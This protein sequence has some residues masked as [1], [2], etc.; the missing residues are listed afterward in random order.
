MTIA[1]VGEVLM[2]LFRSEGVEYIFGLPGLTEVRFLD[3]LEN[4][5]EIKYIMGLN[6]NVCIGMADGYT[7]AS[8]KIGV[9]NLHTIAGTSAALGLLLNSYT[10]EVPL[11][12][13][14]GQQDSRL[15]AQEPRLWGDLVKITESFTKWGAE[16]VYS[17]D[18]PRIIQRAFKTALQAPTGP[19]FVSLP[20]NLFEQNI[21]FDFTPHMPHFDELRPDTHALITA[22]EIIKTAHNPAIIVESGVAKSNALSEVVEL[23]ELLGAPV[24]QWWMS[25]V[26]FPVNH[27]QYLG[28]L[29][30]QPK[31]MKMMK[32]SDVLIVIGAPQYLSTIYSQEPPYPKQPGLFKLMKIPMK[33]K[34]TSR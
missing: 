19:V 10:G 22:C 2:Q 21:N 34:K 13:T 14:S 7:R 8:G 33:L 31:L 1:P 24:F 9:V 32:L 15:F 3:V 18:V 16:I 20:Q 23:A 5:P 11:L 29:I 30:G 25:D 26:N 12:I 6:E 4:H 28:E 27:P 17:E